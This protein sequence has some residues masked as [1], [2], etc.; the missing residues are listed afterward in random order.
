LQNELLT[1][2]GVMWIEMHVP[3]RGGGP[4]IADLIGGQVQAVCHG[5]NR[6]PKFDP[7]LECTPLGRSACSPYPEREPMPRKVAV[8]SARA[9]TDDVG[10][11]VPNVGSS[12]PNAHL[13]AGPS[14]PVGNRLHRRP[15]R[16]RRVSLGGWS[17]RT[18]SQR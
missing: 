4:A 18:S 10:D 16:H 9:A 13:V 1:M 6:L 14:G 12:D 3:Y 8:R 7:R 17:I 15:E 11:R 5:A 2:V